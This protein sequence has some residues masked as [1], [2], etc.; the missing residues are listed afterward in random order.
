MKKEKV[1]LATTISEFGWDVLRAIPHILW[2]KRVKYK[3]KLKLIIQIRPDRYDLCGEDAF[4]FYPL[5]IKGDYITKKG[6]CFKITGFNNIQYLKLIENFE[7]KYKD[8]Y[9]I[10]EHIYPKIQG[11]L[12]AK[13][14]QF[15]WNEM[16]HDFK[17]RSRNKELID[18]YITTK[19]PIVIL[20]PRFRKGF[21][22]NWPHWEEL[23]DLIEKD[24]V[25]NQFYFIICGKKP[26]YKPDPKN[27]FFDINSIALDSQSS[28]VGLTIEAMRKSRLTV[29]TQSGLPNLS[30]LLKTHTL[31]WGHQV[32]Q[33]ANS[34]NIKKT[35]CKFIKD[36]R[37]SINPKRIINEM[38]II[39]TGKKEK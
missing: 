16:I 15:N 38:R 20:A 19:K 13:K 9:N 30:N 25:L 4:D 8:E 14:D 33:H 22:R 28:L 39:L 34:Y 24:E 1:I 27:R 6:D 29:G 36:V 18:N 11:K 3:N 12:Y 17:P 32:H 23:Y 10:I 26:E 35:K 21:K 37:Y 2:K 31:Q 7:N 5:Q